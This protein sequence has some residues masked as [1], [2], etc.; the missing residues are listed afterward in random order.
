MNDDL[1][2]LE[3]RIDVMEMLYAMMVAERFAS[4][5]EMRDW[6][7]RTEAQ[8]MRHVLPREDTDPVI[9]SAYQAAWDRVLAAVRAHARMKRG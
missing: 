7:E 8:V 2:R 3:K 6:T 1:L 9:A 4:D 5:A